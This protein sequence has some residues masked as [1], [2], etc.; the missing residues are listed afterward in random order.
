LT[1]KDVVRGQ[2]DGYHEQKGVAK[3]STV[4]TWAA[5]RFHI[6]NDRWNGVPFY[7]RAGKC[8]PVTITEVM[9]R[10]KPT[11]QPVLDEA[12]VGTDGYYRFRLSPHEEIAQGLKIKQPGEAMIGSTGELVIHEKPRDEMPPYERLLGD[13]I[14]GDSTMFSREDS[15]EAAWRVLDPILGDVTPVHKY[16]KGTWGP[17]EVDDKIKPNDGWHN[18]VLDESD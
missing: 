7:V 11:M 5:L 9:V 14:K 10:F 1:A 3:D 18:P 17:A 6:D 2:F 8:M 15:V 12:E 13:A 16:A 4:E